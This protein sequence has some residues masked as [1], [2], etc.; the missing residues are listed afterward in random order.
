MKRICKK[1]E[2]RKIVHKE[3]WTEDSYLI[4]FIDNTCKEVYSRESLL[5]EIEKDNKKRI[6]YVFDMRDRIILDRDIEIKEDGEI[7]DE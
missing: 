2:L 7:K 5:E 6:R 1:I 3:M 4:W